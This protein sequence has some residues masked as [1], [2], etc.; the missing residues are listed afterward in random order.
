[1]INSNPKETL[2]QITDDIYQVRLPLPFALNI[3]NV[4]LLRDKAG[5]TIIDTGIHTPQGES[6]WRDVLHTLNIHPT[7]IRQ[8]ILTHVH[9]DHFGMA[10]WLQTLGADHNHH[11]PIYASPS[12]DEQIDVIWRNETGDFF[13]QWLIENGMPDEFARKVADSMGNTRAMTLPH[14]PTV[15]HLAYD[16]LVSMAGRSWQA[17]HSPGH[18]DGHLMFYD[19]DSQLLLSGDHVLMHITPNIGLW[20]HTEADPLGRFMASLASLK[21]LSVVRALPGH[22]WHITDWQGRIEELIGHHEHR[23][24]LVEAGIGKG[25]RTPYDI[26]QTIF[27]TERFTPHE[28]RF[29]IAES[30]AHM[31]YLHHRRKLVQIGD[32]RKYVSTEAS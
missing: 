1:M 2:T 8:I 17:I 14:P 13:Y 31:E 25:D 6:T 28:W 15:E 30:L 3:V 29:A 12:E 16:A 4:Y 19:A 27:V 26:T 23:L 9:P 5:W 10:G 21:D 22:K 24:G 32:E 11:I 18:S 20:S 7:H